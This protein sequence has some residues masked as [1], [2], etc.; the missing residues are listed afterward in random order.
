MKQNLLLEVSG[1][2]CEVLGS[3]SPQA[4]DFPQLEIETGEPLIPLFWVVAEPLPC[5]SC[6]A[7][8]SWEIA[9]EA[10]PSG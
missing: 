1:D 9:E 7:P 2:L 6:S 10:R 5:T 4:F 8:A 3:L